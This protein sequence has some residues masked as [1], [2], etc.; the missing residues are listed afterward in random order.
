METN[1]CGAGKGDIRVS[2]LPRVT[3]LS[4]FPGKWLSAQDDFKWFPLVWVL[5]GREELER[6]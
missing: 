4:S 3:S 5:S 2:R 1:V 6:V